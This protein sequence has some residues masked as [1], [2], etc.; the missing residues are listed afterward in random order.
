M[1]AKKPYNHSDYVK[2]KEVEIFAKHY[3]FECNCGK[4]LGR[5]KVFRV[6][7][8]LKIINKDN[9]PYQSYLS[10]FL[11]LNK[12]YKKGN[13][14]S[15]KT[16]IFIKPESEQYLV[17]RITDYLDDHCVCESKK[18]KNNKELSNIT[19]DNQSSGNE[20]VSCSSP[21][22]YTREEALKWL[23]KLPEFLKNKQ[24]AIDLR[25]KWG[26]DS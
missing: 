18:K 19:I 20:I 26:I 9:V 21:A 10:N 22:D 15:N 3:N 23:S 13:V 8:R 2:C 6:L 5:N 17:K 11:T 4:F 25:K 12:E 1:Q 16:H 24:T 14:S 7:R